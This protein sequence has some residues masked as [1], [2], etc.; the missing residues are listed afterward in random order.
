[1]G[2]QSALSRGFLTQD[3]LGQWLASL[4]IFTFGDIYFVDSGHARAV[5]SVTNSGKSP[6][7]PFATLAYAAT[8]CTASTDDIIVVAARHAET[9]TAAAGIDLSVAGVSVIGMGKG[10]NRPTITIGTATSATF[11][12]SAVN[13]LVKNVRFTAGTAQLLVKMI[14]ATAGDLTME[15]CYFEGAST[16]TFLVKSFVNLTTTKDNFTFRRC[17]WWQGTDPNGTDG[18]ADSGAIYMVDTENVFLEDCEFYGNFETAFI[19]NKTT[20]AKNVWLKNC[21]GRQA[22]SGAEP[23]QLVDGCTG[24]AYGGLFITPA[25]AAATEAT[26]VGTVGDSFFIS[27]TCTFGNDGGAGGQGGI[28][29]ATAS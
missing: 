11:K 19:H 4:G 15:D 20:A 3:T 2:F 25:E 9:I 24:G 27:P 7:S 28:V 13:Q 21:R 16:S 29:V 26:L 1:M 6:T 22:L 5:D 14:D 10:S 8:R 12:A 17:K 23:F 18:G